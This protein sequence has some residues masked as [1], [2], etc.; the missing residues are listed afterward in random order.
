MVS[1]PDDAT[2]GALRRFAETG[3]DLSKPME[4]EFFVAVPSKN[5]GNQVAPKAK[6]LGFKVSLEQD[7]E[8]KEWICYCVKTLVPEYDEVVS[9]ERQLTS[10]AMP[11]G[12]YAD[13]FG[14]F[15][16]GKRVTGP[17]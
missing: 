3:S 4:I 11:F 1:L 2:G 13:G 8:S 6:D 15:G 9:L 17:D 10:I 16:N 5:V 12:G 7:D 14:S